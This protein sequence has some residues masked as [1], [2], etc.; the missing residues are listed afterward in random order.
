MHELGTRVPITFVGGD[1]AGAPSNAATVTLTI[2]LPDGTTVTPTV[3]NPPARTGIYTYDYLT[4]QAGRH[5]WFA[6]TTG[7]TVAYG[8]T[9]FNVAPTGPGGIIGLDEA[10]QHLNMDLARTV[11]DAELR[12]FLAAATP[13]VEDVVGVVVARSFT[14]VHDR[15]VVLVLHRCPA[16][17]LTTLV[18]VYTGGTSYLPADLDL[19]TETAV[20]RRKDGGGFAGPL[21][22]TY[23]AGRRIVPPN[24]IQGTKEIVRHM[25][26]TQRAP[27]TGRPGLGSD[28]ELV[29]TGSGYLIPRRAMELLHPHHR[30]PI[31]A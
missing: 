20:V 27:S 6:T 22:V 21:R 4:T 29:A 11:D 14:E 28:D 7:P 31:A 12:G 17:S 23:L 19:D 16:I 9:V 30:G 1:V 26:S 15:G 5:I 24:I 3:V 13:V 8:P 18:P 25:W 10:K 2:T